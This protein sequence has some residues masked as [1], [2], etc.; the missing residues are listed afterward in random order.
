M[1]IFQAV[2][3]GLIQGLAEFLPISS[4]AHLILAPWFFHWQDPGLSF[5]IALHLGTLIAIIAYLWKDW[6]AIFLS[7]FGKPIR[8]R[9]RPFFTSTYRHYTKNYLWLLVAATIPGALIGYLLEHYAEKTFR[10]PLLV[11]SALGIM[12]FILYLADR[13]TRRTRTLGQVSLGDALIIGLSQAFAIVPGVSRS[14]A[15]ISAALFL[16]LDRVSAARFSFLLSTPI[17]FGAV[18]LKL[19]TFIRAGFGVPE[20]IG[21]VVSAISGYIAIAGLIKLISR[22]SYKAFFLYRLCLALIVFAVYF[23]R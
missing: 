2:V 19:N 12:G 15:T 13:R 18:V 20:V 23:L 11:A 5:D 14:G 8:N 1:S 4:S 7:A 21:I 17:I 10:H 16:G 22:V 9:H 6:L 3:Y